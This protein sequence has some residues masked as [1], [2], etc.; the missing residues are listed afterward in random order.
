M[1][2]G[3]RAAGGSVQVKVSVHLPR[4]L[5]LAYL[6]LGSVLLPSGFNILRV[7]VHIYAALCS[8]VLRGPSVPF[9]CLE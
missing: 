8:F 1:G 4:T 7:P 9:P 6:L 3:L 2:G 5:I